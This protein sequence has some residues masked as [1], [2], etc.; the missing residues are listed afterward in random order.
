ML[1]SR[2]DIAE[3]SRNSLAGCGCES[4]GGTVTVR[5]MITA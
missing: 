5:Q 4:R 2:A 1:T 3:S